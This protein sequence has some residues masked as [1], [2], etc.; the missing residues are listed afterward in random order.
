MPYQI[1]PYSLIALVLSGLGE[2]RALL[3]LVVNLGHLN[4]Q[5]QRYFSFLVEKAPA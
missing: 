4:A 5:Y 3:G 1:I 2:I